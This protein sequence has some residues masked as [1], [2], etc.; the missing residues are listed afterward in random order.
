[1][2]FQAGGEG[3]KNPRRTFSGRRR[4]TP[5]SLYAGLLV[6]LFLLRCIGLAAEPRY[7]ATVLQGTRY[8]TVEG[9]LAADGATLSWKGIPYA[10]PPV[11]PL[12]WKAPRDPGT[13]DGVL[14]TKQYQQRSVQLAGANAVGSEDCLYLNIWRPNTS[15]ENLPVLVFVHGGSN[16]SGSGEAWKGDN[17]ARTANAVI[18]SLNYRLGIMGWFNHAALVSGDK[19]AD[20]G[21]FGLLDIIKSLEWVRDNIRSFGGD[22]GNVTLSGFSAGAATRW[23]L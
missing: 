13:W 2:K 16:V 14:E 10:K 8:G 3:P 22:P 11:G 23:P 20:S 12:R 7:S 15:E 17:L 6:A 5:R 1:M 9:V 18:I 19:S 21:N 4:A